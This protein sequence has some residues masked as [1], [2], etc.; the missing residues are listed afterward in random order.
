MV[1]WTER[2]VGWCQ[3]MATLPPAAI[4]SKEGGGWWVAI[5]WP[6]LKP[7]PAIGPVR[8]TPVTDWH[9]NKQEDQRPKGAYHPI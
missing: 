8:K 9:L 7:I 5:G 1:L 3:N 6:W 4:E 2:R